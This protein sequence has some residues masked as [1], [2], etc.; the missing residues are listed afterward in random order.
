MASRPPEPTPPSDEEVL[1]V[2]ATMT[3]AQ[4]R[5][6]VARPGVRKRSAREFL[7]L[8]LY[9]CAMGP[10][11]ARG[12]ARGHAKGVVAVGDIATGIFAFGGWARGLFAFGGVATGVCAFG[13]VSLGLLSALGGAALSAGLAIGG[14]AAGSIAVGGAAAGHYAVGGG[15]YGTYVASP[16]RTDPE[17][18]ELFEAFGIDP[19]RQPPVRRAPAR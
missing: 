15:T 13:G 10:D 5:L 1:R 11:P 7:G 12:E 6:L 19:P 2:L 3:P 14:A 9:D 18:V 17:V 16:L 4:R 8:P